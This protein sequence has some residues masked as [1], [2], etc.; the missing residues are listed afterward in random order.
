MDT[1]GSEAL[2]ESTESLND[3]TSPTQNLQSASPNEAS[4]IHTISILQDGDS[5]SD[6]SMSAD[7]DDDEDDDGDNSPSIQMHAGPEELFQPPPP[8]EGSKKRKHYDSTEDIP[9]SHRTNGLHVEVHKRF[10]PEEILQSCRTPTG[11][12]KQDPSLLPAEIW[13]HIFIFT[14]PRTLGL[15]MQVNK[16]FN[17]YLDPSS[18]KVPTPLSK[19]AVRLLKPDTIWRASRRLFRPT[20]P[21]PLQGQSEIQMWRM[22]CSKTCQFC[23]KKKQPNNIAQM[24]QWHPGPGENGVIPIWSFAIRSCGPCLQQQ[25]VKVGILLYYALRSHH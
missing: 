11:H 14:P 16:S 6:V 7:S 23:G 22:A 19:S 13:H 4:D 12:L 8:L 9:N 24:T 2:S 10:K 25:S 15:L 5:D 3:V 21:V 18:D 20:M 17:A 1:P